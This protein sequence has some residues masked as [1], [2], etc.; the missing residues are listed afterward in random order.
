M[1][2]LSLE[3]V[4]PIF[5]ICPQSETAMDQESLRE[6]LL[7]AFQGFHT[8]TALSLIAYIA[9]HWGDL[10]AKRDRHEDPRIISEKVRDFIFNI[11]E[12]S[13]NRPS[14]FAGRSASMEETWELGLEWANR[15]VKMPEEETLRVFGE[16]FWEWL[17]TA[18]L[19]M[20]RGKED[21][22]FTVVGSAFQAW[23]DTAAV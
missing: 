3:L 23:R 11:R 19:S 21:T 8:V 9:V 13:P 1:E 10:A 4:I 16:A 15:L 22:D 20:Y 18:D 17:L 6:S 12:P 7:E 14:F 5:R 2:E